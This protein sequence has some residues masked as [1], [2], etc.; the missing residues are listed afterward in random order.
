M[1][2]T[3]MKRGGGFKQMA[4]VRKRT[5]H[6]PI[7]LLHRRGSM[8]AV[9][10]APAEAQP[11]EDAIQHEG[12]MRLVRQFRC[13][14]CGREGPSQFCHMDRGKGTG[15]K[16]DCRY[17]WP[18]CGPHDGMPGCH[19]LIGT[20]RIYPKEVRRALESEMSARTRAEIE[21]LGLWPK[22]LP[23]LEID[24]EALLQSLPEL[25]APQSHL[26]T[27]PFQNPGTPK[28]LSTISPTSRTM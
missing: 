23:R 28:W 22:R 7:P 18:G 20:Q 16:S 14:H 8:V 11:K 13:A 12:Y 5:V 10:C 17:G 4:I 2:R 27:T 1:K 15:I 6:T 25:K 19:Y 26:Q 21:A 3:P 9:E 24:K